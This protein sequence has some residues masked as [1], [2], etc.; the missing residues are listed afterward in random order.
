[1]NEPKL[2]LGNSAS[3]QILPGRFVDNSQEISNAGLNKGASPV[4]AKPIAGLR[5]PGPIGQ[6]SIN[7]S[8]NHSNF[9]K[10]VEDKDLGALK[11]ELE[12]QKAIKE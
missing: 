6:T 8:L 5:K 10:T 4:L 2:S 12:Y 3:Q 9:M 11:K 7:S 1:M